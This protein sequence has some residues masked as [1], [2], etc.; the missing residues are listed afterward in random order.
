MAPDSCFHNCSGVAL[1]GGARGLSGEGV[2]GWAHAAASGEIGTTMVSTPL[3]ERRERL[4]VP[5][6]LVGQR[7][8]CVLY[9]LLDIA[10][11]RRTCTFE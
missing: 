4:A 9:A 8:L 7:V 10:A 1:T 3:A 5:L 6:G 2:G 11:P